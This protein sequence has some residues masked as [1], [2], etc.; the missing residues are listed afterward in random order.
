MPSEIDA[1]APPGGRRGA[2]HDPRPR[3]RRR[4]PA[5]RPRMLT[6]KKYVVLAHGLDRTTADLIRAAA[7]AGTIEAVTLEPE[8]VRVYPHEG[9]G[10]E[11]DARR[12]APRLRQPRRR[13]PVRRRAVLPGRSWPAVRRIVH[14]QRDVSGRPIPDTAVVEDPGTPGE[15]IR[16]TID[17]GL[18]LA[19]EQE[20]LAA[21]AADQAK[22]VSAVVMDP[23][24]GEV[25]AEATYPSYDAQRLPGDRGRRP[26]PVHR[27]DRQLRLRARLGVQDADRDRRPRDPR[28][29]RRRRRSRT[30]GIAQARRRPD[31]RRRRRPQG[32][33]AG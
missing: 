29:S 8:P 28:R 3:G 2:R 23:Y 1:A 27:P 12:A 20:V 25:L 15:D 5:D 32:P 4:R 31:P 18:Q 14:A 16:L 26:Q 7:T 19:L 9:G 11:F 30:S 6:D 24:T 22:S 17:A 13:R 33:R 10:P 21:W